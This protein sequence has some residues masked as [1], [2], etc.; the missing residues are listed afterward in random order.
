MLR[1][2]RKQLGARAKLPPLAHELHADSPLALAALAV[3]LDEGDRVGQVALQAARVD[4]L[5]LQLR[6]PHEH[7]D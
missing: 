7:I 1:P 3:L 6:A 2:E 4:A 5:V